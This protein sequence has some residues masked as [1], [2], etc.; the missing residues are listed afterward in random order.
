MLDVLTVISVVN[1]MMLFICVVTGLAWWAGEPGSESRYWFDASLMQLFGTLI[2]SAGRYIHLDLVAFGAGFLLSA[3]TGYVT[4][5]YRQ[6][7]GMRAQRRWP[8]LVALATATATFLVRYGSGGHDDGWYLI[9]FGAAFSLMWGARAV[10]RGS[11]AAEMRFGRA[12]ALLLVAYSAGCA[13]VAPLAFFFPVQY[14]DGKPQ[15]LWLELSAVPL[16]VLN[17]AAYLMTLIVKLERATERQRQLATRDALTGALN[18]RAFYE[19]WS[20]V[21]DRG[22]VMAILDI[23]HFKSV[24]DT[25]GH[26]AGDVALETVA[27]AI[28]TTLPK[29]ALFGRLG[30]EEFGIL[31]PGQDAAVAAQLLEDLRQSVRSKVIQSCEGR[32]FAV[33]FSAGFVVFDRSGGDV[34]RIFA[35][36]DCALYVAKSTGRDRIVAFDP[37]M[38]LRQEADLMKVA[39]VDAPMKAFTG[40]SDPGAAEQTSSAPLSFSVKNA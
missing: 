8:L 30:G 37:P 1:A 28:A 5:G 27:A 9:Y 20:G 35:A 23:D 19:A 32:R 18:R 3:A 26:L 13:I 11:V 10:W 29:T 7:Y 33:T 15:S 12:A 4:L 21:L 40:A 36:A 2:L 22:G 25:H 34:N 24:N 16:F 14:V 38:L 17:M 31:F 6:L 39:A